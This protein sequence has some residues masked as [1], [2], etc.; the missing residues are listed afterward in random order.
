MEGDGKLKSRGASA[1]GSAIPS[2]CGT[3]CFTHMTVYSHLDQ[4]M[5]NLGHGLGVSKP[6]IQS[7]P[8]VRMHMVPTR[9]LGCI[10]TTIPN[11]IEKLW[12]AK[13]TSARTM[14]HQSTHGAGSWGGFNPKFACW[15]SR[16]RA[17]ALHRTVA[18][19]SSIS[20]HQFDDRVPTKASHCS[21]R[22]GFEREFNTSAYAPISNVYV[23]VC[24]IRSR[25]QGTFVACVSHSTLSWKLFTVRG[26]SVLRKTLRLF[27]LDLVVEPLGARH[28]EV[29]LRGV[30]LLRHPDVHVVLDEACL[31]VLVAVAHVHEDSPG[32]YLLARERPLL[33]RGDLRD[34]DLR[35][36]SQCVSCKLESTD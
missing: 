14:G 35:D 13:E 15:A 30:R 32:A 18:L 4:S 28:G 3:H 33:A 22:S 5:C 34:S 2:S 8:G 36:L 12:L 16:Y 21:A 1:A 20:L 9:Q 23:T 29:P 26:S 6:P 25:L 7:L 24:F 19:S 27:G 17:C 10:P 31:E 11:H